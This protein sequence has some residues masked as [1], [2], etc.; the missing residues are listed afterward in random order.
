MIIIDTSSKHII[1][2]TQLTTAKS[3]R[4]AAKTMTEFFSSSKTSA[5]NSKFNHLINLM[6]LKEIKQQQ[7][8]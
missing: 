2:I 1:E 4:V 3:K 8:Q 5:F 6:T 7:K